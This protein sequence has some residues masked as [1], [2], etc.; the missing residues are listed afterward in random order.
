[1]KKVSL[2]LTAVLMTAV[3][4]TSC[5]WFDSS[6]EARL[7]SESEKTRLKDEIIAQLKREAE[8]K[9]RKEEKEA[10]S[11]EVSIGKQLWLTTNLNVDQFSN[12]DEIPQAKTAEEWE[13]AGENGQP[14]WCYYNNDP[15]NGAKYGKL[16]NWFTVIDPR[17]L[18]PLGWKIPSNSDFLIL[19]SFI[20]QDFKPKMMKMN[21]WPQ[22][23]G[24]SNKFGFSG[25][26]GGLRDNYGNFRNIGMGAYFWSNT[27]FEGPY[28]YARELGSN[29]GNYAG[30]EFGSN[31]SI[32]MSVRCIKE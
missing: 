3:M 9:R 28:A 22:A 8:E 6:Q 5:A 24:A 31:K 29:A 27:V 15:S 7:K 13:K 25:I 10:S 17:G 12:G 32:G 23:E 20:G 1:M 19:T 30:S 21:S 16:Y 18:A 11:K 14:A 26:P 4:I 2:N